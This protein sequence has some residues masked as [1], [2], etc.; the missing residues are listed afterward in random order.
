MAALLALMFLYNRTA[1]MKTRP[2]WTDEAGQVWVSGAPTPDEMHQRA[3]AW[4]RHPPGYSWLLRPFA[5]AGSS[6]A[7]LRALSV[8]AGILSLGCAWGMAR[9][10]LPRWE[11][12]CVVLLIG[13][14]PSLALYSREARP[15]AVALLAL[16]LF[17][18]MLGRHWKAPSWKTALGL[19]LA[20]ASATLFLY[21]SS[22]VMGTTLLT[23]LACDMFAPRENA[24]ACHRAGRVVDCRRICGTVALD[25]V[26]AALR[27]PV[28]DL[29]HVCGRSAKRRI[30]PGSGPVPHERHHV[31]AGLSCTRARL[32]PAMGDGRHDPGRGAAARGVARRGEPVASWRWR[33]SPCCVDP[34]DRAGLHDTRGDPPA[35]LRRWKA[36]PRSGSGRV[37][38]RWPPDWECCGPG[39][40][41]CRAV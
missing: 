16:I 9:T 25:S 20:S 41:G 40:R 28:G 17:F 39:L 30:A 37:S 5:L 4:D 34:G 1:D 21:S 13:S 2:L 26:P 11:A 10:W 35:S 29:S 18:W 38:W 22:I 19:T 36:L 31:A 14:S 15:Y 8:V 33:P 27:R 32:W 12:G 6:E 3:L 24:R 23:A 7:M